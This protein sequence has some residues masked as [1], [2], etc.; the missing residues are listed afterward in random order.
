MN[1]KIN[2]QE[3][4]NNYL[5]YFEG[6]KLERQRKFGFVDNY[7]ESIKRRTKTFDNSEPSS[8]M[9]SKRRD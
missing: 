6:K 2:H 4:I 5:K 3:L 9:F 8:K 7:L 1:M